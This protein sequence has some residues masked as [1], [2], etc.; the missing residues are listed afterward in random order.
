MSFPGQPIILP[1]R[2]S[3]HPSNL[4]TQISPYLFTAPLL[5]LRVLRWSQQ[6]CYKPDARQLTSP[7]YIKMARTHSGVLESS[8]DSTNSDM[9]VRCGSEDFKLYKDIVC[10]RSKFFAKAC[11]RQSQVIDSSPSGKAYY[12]AKHCN[13]RKQKSPPLSLRMIYRLSIEC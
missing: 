4:V 10:P 13:S 7:H 2:Q 9:T 3:N 5:P 1:P 12:P 6:I 11:H 8:K